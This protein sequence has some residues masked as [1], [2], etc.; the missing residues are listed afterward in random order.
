MGPALASGIA[1]L[2]NAGAMGIMLHRRG[3][4]RPDAQLRA[5]IPKICLAS[6]LMGAILW[7]GQNTL[8]TPFNHHGFERWLGLMVL[9]GVGALVYFAAA[10]ALGVIKIGPVVK[11]FKKA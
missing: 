3:L 1:G 4:I 8:F 5:R 6:L 10:M 7:F 11:R 9:V 2:A